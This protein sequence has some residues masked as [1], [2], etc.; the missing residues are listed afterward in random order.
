M[1]KYIA[2]HMAAR[3]EAV[4]RIWI[5]EHEQK[6]KESVQQIMPRVISFSVGYLVGAQGKG[7]VFWLVSV[8]VYFALFYFLRYISRVYKINWLL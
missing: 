2:P 6:K 5:A 7:W 8:G 4:K 3:T 1:P